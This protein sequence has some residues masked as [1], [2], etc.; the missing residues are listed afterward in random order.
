[1]GKSASPRAVKQ[2]KRVEVP[3][4]RLIARSLALSFV[5]IL[6]ILLVLVA[7]DVRFGQG[8]FAYRYSPVRNL[9]TF[10]AAPV[11]AIAGLAV[12]GIWYLSRGKRWLAR[13]LLIA[14]LV[15]AG[16][17]LSFAPPKPVEQHAFNLRS[18]SSDGAFVTEAEGI[19]SLPQYLRRF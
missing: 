17:W 7:L 13:G 2:P 3:R 4:S 15:G 6:G 1:M 5:A 9:R 14:A 10:R 12:G 19:A 16:A 18:M 11:L 8:F